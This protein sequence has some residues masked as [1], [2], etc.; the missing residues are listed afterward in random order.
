MM[1]NIYEDYSIQICIE[2]LL[3]TRNSSWIL[4]YS[5][6]KDVSSLDVW[7]A[8]SFLGGGEPVAGGGETIS[9]KNNKNKLRSKDIVY[10][11]MWSLPKAAVRGLDRTIYFSQF[12]LNSFG[13]DQ[14]SVFA[15]FPYQAENKISHSS[16]PSRSQ[17][18]R[19][20]S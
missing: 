13:I 18:P 17:T 8:E 4:G 5:N 19:V 1:K 15:N 7:V 16:L 12:I 10:T 20:S 14:M 9:T 3:C 2:Q 6:E 11:Q